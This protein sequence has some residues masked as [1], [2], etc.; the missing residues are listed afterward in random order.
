MTKIGFDLISDLN[1]SP[2]N[3]FNWEGKATSLYC[4]IAGNISY[5][6]PTI[7]K[8]LNILSRYYQGVFYVLG[9]LEYQDVD[10]IPIRT[11]QLINAC[12]RI[13]NVAVLHQNVVIIDGVAILGANGWYGN[14]LPTDEAT[15]EKIDVHRYEDL[16]YLKNSL[17]KL[18]K[19]L[20]VKKILMVTNS[21]PN[22]ELYYREVPIFVENQMSLDLVLFADTERK[23]SHWAFGTHKKIV[24]TTINGINYFN[25]PKLG[26][27]PYWAK[28]IEVTI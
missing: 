27:E 8:T 17:D 20:D 11:N 26:K 4:I 25:N 5:D 23:I 12:G 13:K 3:Q 16:A 19:H 7:V 9:A 1:L 15:E 22:T 24:D 18:Q 2:E 14:T 10:D 28:R 21:V 6:V